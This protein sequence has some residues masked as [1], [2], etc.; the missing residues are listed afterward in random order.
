MFP[1][2]EVLMEAIRSHMSDSG[3]HEQTLVSPIS[4]FDS[5]PS[6]NNSGTNLQFYA[7]PSTKIFTGT[8]Y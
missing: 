3:L 4:L 8:P 2:I 5:F 7:L 1:R 6:R